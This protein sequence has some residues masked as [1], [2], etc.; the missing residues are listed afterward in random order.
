MNFLVILYGWSL[1]AAGIND[2]LQVYRITGYAQGTTYSI[3]YYAADSLVSKS[4]IDDQLAQ[5]DSSLSIYKSYS[6][7]NRFNASES[8]CEVDPYLQAVVQKGQEVHQATGGA[9]DITILPF[10]QAWGFGARKTTSSPS[11]TDINQLKSCVGSS[12]I[13]FRGSYLYKQ[14]PCVQLDVNGI[15]QGYSVDLL[16]QLL[17]SKGIHNYLVELGGEICVKGTK[18]NGEQM[19]IGI[20]APAPNDFAWTPLRKRIQFMD[21]AIATSGNYRR[22]Y[23][24]GGKKITHLIDPVTGHPRTNELVSVTVYAPDAITADAYDNAFMLMG[25]QPSMAFLE[26]ENKMEAY[27]IYRKANGSIADTA[28]AG[29]YTMIKD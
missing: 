20:E 25:L 9:F 13:S 1:L 12:K 14:H 17:Q 3:T 7:I 16:A 24:S 11:D 8:G 2:P 4:M 28:T 27:F 21:G 22:Y 26:N 6:L 5:I 15:A 23:E 10:V 19:K 18:P 29:M